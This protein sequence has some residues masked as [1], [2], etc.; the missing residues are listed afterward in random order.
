MLYAVT[1]F[2]AKSNNRTET[3][4]KNLSSNQLEK[5]RALNSI[6][7]KLDAQIKSE[8]LNLQKQLKTRVISSSDW[9]NDF[10]IIASLE[11]YDNSGDDPIFELMVCT[12]TSS[13]EEPRDLYSN[14]FPAEFIEK[15]GKPS[16]I[17]EALF[18]FNQFSLDDILK[19]DNVWVDI[20][21][22][23]QNHT[24]VVK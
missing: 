6:F 18:M 14:I 4:F 22:I 24:V 21:T 3:S 16:F 23:L 8:I 10:E 20:K 5:F 13:I 19:I 2:L 1:K 7:T 12:N 9:I 17:L 15:I 11:L